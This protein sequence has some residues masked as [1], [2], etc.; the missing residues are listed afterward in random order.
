MLEELTWTGVFCEDGFCF[1]HSFDGRGKVEV[2]DLTMWETVKV[3][4]EME[5]GGERAGKERD[6]GS[7]REEERWQSSQGCQ[8]HIGSRVG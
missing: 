2:K 7:K 3:E 6:S 5:Q 1:R 4:T 8:G